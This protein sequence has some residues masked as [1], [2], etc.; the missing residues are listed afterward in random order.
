MVVFDRSL[1]CCCCCRRQGR[2]IVYTFETRQTH[3]AV[4]IYIYIYDVYTGH[5]TI[6]RLFLK[7]N[8]SRGR[9]NVNDRRRES[10]GNLSLQQRYE[11]SDTVDELRCSAH[12]TVAFCINECCPFSFDRINAGGDSTYVHEL[13]T[14]GGIFFSGFIPLNA[15]HTWYIASVRTM[16]GHNP[17]FIKSPLTLVELPRASTG[18]CD[19]IHEEF[20]RVHS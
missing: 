10:K 7:P 20:R 2:L 15:R 9:E 6:Q 19:T 16:T 17:L 5:T 4:E 12:G 13:H 14:R 18:P 11:A 3:A 8:I 1:L